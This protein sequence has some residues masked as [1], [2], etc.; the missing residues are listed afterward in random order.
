M[1]NHDSHNPR[2][3]CEMCGRWGRVNDIDGNQLNFTFEGHLVGYPEVYY[4]QLCIH[5][6]LKFGIVCEPYEEVVTSP[7]SL[8]EEQE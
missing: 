5:C 3:Q 8:R 7:N 4:S 6:H 1:N 2:I